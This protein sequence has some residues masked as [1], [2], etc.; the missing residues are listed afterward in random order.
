MDPLSSHSNRLAVDR[1]Y[2]AASHRSIAHGAISSG[3]TQRV[4]TL[5]RAVLVA[6]LILATTRCDLVEPTDGSALVV[7]AFLESGEPLPTVTLRQT[8]DL[9]DPVPPTDSLADAAMGA[10]LRIAIDGDTVTYLPGEVAGTYEP[11]R[12]VVVQPGAS[13]FLDVEWEDERATASGRVPAPID[14]RRACLT[15]PTTPVRAILVDSLRRDSLDIPAEQGFIFPVD[16]SVDWG[17]NSV[18]EDAWVRAGLQPSSNFSSGIVELFLQPTEV[19]REPTFLVSPAGPERQWTGVYAV[20]AADS[21]DPVPAHRITVSLTRGDSAFASFA[22]SRTDPERREPVS[23]VDGAIGIAT[24]IAL[25]TI[26]FDVEQGA[27][28]DVCQPP[29]EP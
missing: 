28:G 12:P 9:Q 2:R 10:T 3:V 7:E 6:V 17:E 16:A 8:R 22:S 1:P 27:R 26:G 14:I 13:F 18:A 21:T 19:N 5:L 4:R 11:A 23:N 15:I 20:S 25:D 24:A 29:I